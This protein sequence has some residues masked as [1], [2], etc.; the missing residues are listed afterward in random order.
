MFKKK[1]YNT[2]PLKFVFLTFL[3]SFVYIC[4]YISLFLELRL[5]GCAIAMDEVDGCRDR[6]SSYRILFKSWQIQLLFLKCIYKFILYDISISL[7]DELYI[8]SATRQ[9]ILLKEYILGYG[10]NEIW[11]EG[12]S[13]SV[14]NELREPHLLRSIAS[15]EGK[16]NTQRPSPTNRI[17]HPPLLVRWNQWL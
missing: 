7:S 6:D 5:S 13:C 11:K 1:I 10:R 17:A 12:N 4:M 15:N 14:W 3:S 9:F 16:L 2:M 8:R